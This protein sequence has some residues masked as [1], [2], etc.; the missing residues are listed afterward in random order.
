MFNFWGS[1]EIKLHLSDIQSTIQGARE[2][3]DVDKDFSNA[4]TELRNDLLALRESVYALNSMASENKYSNVVKNKF[5]ARANEIVEGI[6]YPESIFLADGFHESM[7]NKMTELG[8][9]NIKEFKHL[10]MFKNEMKAIA[11]N[12]KSVEGS[13][14]NI[15]KLL[16]YP[17]SRNAIKTG[18]ILTAIKGEESS[19]ATAEE[20][21]KNIALKITEAGESITIKRKS[22]S[23]A[24][25]SNEY[26]RAEMMRKE[27]DILKLNE[28][29]IETKISEEFAS[30]DRI[31]KKFAHYNTY[32]KELVNK[33]I[34]NSFAAFLADEEVKIKIILDRMRI[35]IETGKI[36]IENKK[37]H[38]LLDII[39]SM[40]L[41]ES[42]RRQYRELKNQ[43]V[44]MTNDMPAV[45][46]DIRRLRGEIED[47]ESTIAKLRKDIELRN[48]NIAAGKQKLEAMRSELAGFVSE[49][50]GKNAVIIN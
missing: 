10:Q 16:N 33:Y 1:K 44:E 38:R 39:R 35:G 7:K 29:T 17:I 32:E 34:D 26:M 2:I 47:E 36:A 37:Y 31:F 50:L 5:C 21:I 30:I 25:Q 46:N 11:D 49:I 27:I 40:S 18:K 15:G 20:Q 43:Q 13:I 14:D 48:K 4:L 41:F 42:L 23:Q 12:I 3:R 19:I 9:L 8:S 45:E 28:K 24:L 6:E 22:L